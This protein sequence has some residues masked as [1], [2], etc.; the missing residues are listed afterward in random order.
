MTALFRLFI[1]TVALGAL[2]V[3]AMLAVTFLVEPTPRDIV[4]EVPPA[5]FHK[6]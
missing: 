5:R 4:V 2:A 6:P 3:G 1:W